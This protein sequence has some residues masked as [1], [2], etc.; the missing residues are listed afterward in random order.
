MESVTVKML[1]IAPNEKMEEIMREIA[2]EFD[3]LTLDTHVGNLQEGAEFAREALDQG[4]DVI[5]SRGET[6]AMIKS[7]SPVPVLEIKYSF[8]D[9]VHA[10]KIAQT[11]GKPF[12]ILGFP[13]I[14]DCAGRLRDLLQI[15]LDI[16]TVNDA[17]QAPDVVHS[18]KSRN[19]QMVITGMCLD[20]L[21]RR[22]GLQYIPIIS[23]KESIRETVDTAFDLCM[24]YARE[25]RRGRFLDQVIRSSSSDVL[26]YDSR[27]SLVYSSARFLGEK[28]AAALTRKDL[29]SLDNADLDMV[30]RRGSTLIQSSK[31]ILELEGDAHTA[32]YLKPS[33]SSLPAAKNDISYY[34]RSEAAEVFLKNEVNIPD[35]AFTSSHSLEQMAA[36]PLPVLITGEKGTGKEALAAF[37]YTQSQWSAHPYVMINFNSLGEKAWNFLTSH[38]DSPFNSNHSTIYFCGLEALSS[39]KLERLTSMIRDSSLCGRNRV[40]LSCAVTPGKKL[41]DGVENLARLF[42]CLTVSLLP[43]RQR[44]AEIPA[45]A[46]LAVSSL[47]ME[48]GCQIIGP[49]PEAM[50]RLAAYPWP[51]NLTQLRSVLASLVASAQS[52]YIQEDQVI[53]CLTTEDRLSPQPVTL[54]DT[55]DLRKPLAEI[56]KDILTAVLAECGGNQSQAARRLGICRTTL[57]RLLGKS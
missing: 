40:L 25:K 1:G 38:I 51:G 21:V 6:A 20:H 19:V 23:S 54:P 29:T 53:K 4:Y 5:L 30:K 43:L 31:R 55:L 39:Q 35:T 50:E 45:L 11:F 33:K 42:S 27:Q 24:S 36:L 44:R 22:C 49:A 14:T 57:W 34:T 7:F 3:G 17:D 52:A 47:N 8:S 9:I 2:L 28:E 26:V 15:P 12:A 10:V 56:E 37:I 13:S 41:P 16:C 46:G 48:L 18:L 32:F